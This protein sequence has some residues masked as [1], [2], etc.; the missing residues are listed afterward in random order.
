[1]AIPAS[2]LVRV[3]QGRLDPGVRRLSALLRVYGLDPEYVSDLVELES[4]A[5]PVPTGDL[6]AIIDRGVAS[7][8]DGNVP[9]ALASV[10]AVR[11]L[12]PQDR[13][14][15]LLR[16]KGTLLFAVYARSLGKTRLARMLVEELLCGPP[17]PT[18]LVDALVLAASLWNRAGSRIVAWA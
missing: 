15:K 1:E 13:S 10:F 3:E 18:L 2:T 9:Q 4:L 7:W 17:D 11:E 14:Q 12:V 16:Q 8:R 5:V 6:R